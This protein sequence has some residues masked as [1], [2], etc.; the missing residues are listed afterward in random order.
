MT[1]PAASTAPSPVGSIW[2]RATVSWMLYDL[3]NT[4]F[5]LNIVSLYF[6]LWV[7]NDM[8][9]TDQLYG[10][11]N[12]LAMI[13][14]FF[15]APVIGALS[16]MSARRM[17]FLIISTIL[18]VL[19]T[20]LLGQGGLMVSLAFFVIATY[21][22][23]AGL[24]FYDALLPVVS[25][26]EN[27]GRVSSLGVGVGY[28]GSF[29]GVGAGYFL[30]EYGFSKITIFQVTAVLFM[31]FAIPCFLWVKEQPRAD[32][33]PITLGAVKDA[34]FA[35]GG[36]LR[37]VGDYQNLGRFLLG[38]VFYADAAN[39]L[40][41]FLGVY[42][43]NELGYTERESQIVLLLGIATAVLGG[44]IWGPLVDRWGPKKTLDL[45]LILWMILL[46]AGAAVPFLPVPDWIFYIIAALSG[47]TLGGTW[48]TDR[49]LMMRL[50]PPRYLGQFYGLYAMVGRFAAI[51]GPILWGVIVDTLGWG[52]PAAIMSLFVLMVIAF[53]ILR[54][55]SDAPREWSPEE[56]IPLKEA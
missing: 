25:T 14:V 34:F 33:R 5:S 23:Q 26:D 29:V 6:S 18:C 49:P 4:I 38:R 19:A 53:F 8:G 48:S 11:F 7:I 28:I 27:R 47:I 9:G 2:N 31:L 30:L 22:F 15:T 20:A 24:I 54:P 36:T 43:T 13:L 32:A 39:T 45:V 17:P 40:V 37:K 21:F 50:S 44:V 10:N 12:A 46:V 52:R 56:L 3:A 55:V 41:A 16:D 1:T 35:V 42:V 51:L